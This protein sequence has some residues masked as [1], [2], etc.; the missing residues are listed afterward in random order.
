M[1]TW[2]ACGFDPRKFTTLVFLQTSILLTAE[3]NYPNVSILPKDT[4]F[5]CIPI[6][7]QAYREITLVNTTPLPIYYHITWDSKL[8]TVE[9]L[10]KEETSVCESSSIRNS[11]EKDEFDD[12]TE[13]DAEKEV[14]KLV[15]DYCQRLF[16]TV[17]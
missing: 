13:D 11:V 9:Y 5:D 14:V 17:T 7:T 1:S 2:R 16:K 3:L 12:T 4:D 6:C 8:S 15:G 10:E